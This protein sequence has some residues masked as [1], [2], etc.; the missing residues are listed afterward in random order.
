MLTL[1]NP[2]ITTG[3]MNLSSLLVSGLNLAICLLI[4][5]WLFPTLTFIL[6]LSW[7][8]PA[9]QGWPIL[10]LKRS[11]LPFRSSSCVSTVPFGHC[12]LYKPLPSLVLIS[13][14]W[15]FPQPEIINWAQFMLADA[16]ALAL[17]QFGPVCLLPPLALCVHMS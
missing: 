6:W 1:L 2:G 4:L 12:Y 17:V 10:I 15:P 5:C 11:R 3:G 7:L 8:E 13:N 9:L 14:Q 16:A